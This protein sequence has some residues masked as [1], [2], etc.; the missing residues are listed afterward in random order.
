MSGT[1]RRECPECGH[2]PILFDP[3]PHPEPD[4]YLCPACDHEWQGGTDSTDET[5][6]YAAAP[7]DNGGTVTI[8]VSTT[9]DEGIR[10]H[11]SDEVEVEVP[12]EGAV[13][14]DIESQEVD[15]AP[16]SVDGNPRVE[17]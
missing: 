10:C 2:D 15:L 3:R 17:R 6:S 5:L 16:N 1:E 4:R 8:T 7:E 12:F 14:I 9:D 13:S 11:D